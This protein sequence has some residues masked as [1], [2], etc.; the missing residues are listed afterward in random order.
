MQNAAARLLSGM[1]LRNNS[2]LVLNEVHRL[3]ISFQ[4]EFK[5]L[6]VIYKDLNC[7]EEGYLKC[8]LLLHLPIQNLRSSMGVLFCVP[9]SERLNWQMS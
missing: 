4:A 2:T 3:P 9:L 5:M 6:V 8:C 1:C 7:L